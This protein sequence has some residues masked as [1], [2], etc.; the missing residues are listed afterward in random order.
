MKNKLTLG[1]ISN[2]HFTVHQGIVMHFKKSKFI[3]QESSIL[4]GKSSTFIKP[5][6]RN[7]SG[8]SVTLICEAVQV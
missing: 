8:Q 1:V 3:S 5:G 4:R 2:M 6:L 7:C